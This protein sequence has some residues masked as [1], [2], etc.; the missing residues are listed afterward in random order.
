MGIGNS[1]GSRL[2]LWLPASL[3][4]E[5]E[6]DPFVCLSGVSTFEAGL[7]F[8]GITSGEECETK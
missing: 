5:L 6:L 8:R 3:E 2:G 4:L 7:A 1:L